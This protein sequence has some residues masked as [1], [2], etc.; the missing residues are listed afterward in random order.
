MG[1]GVSMHYL[2]LVRYSLCC[3]HTQIASVMVA[4]II[5]LLKV[6]QVIPQDCVPIVS[7]CL[8]QVPG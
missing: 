4:I 6:Q 8:Q 5:I 7:V 1:F 2:Y 3:S